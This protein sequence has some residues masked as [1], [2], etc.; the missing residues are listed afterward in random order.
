MSETGRHLAISRRAAGAALGIAAAIVLVAVGSAFGAGGLPVQATAANV[1]QSFGAASG[2]AETTLTASPASGATTAG[3][4]LVV[5]ITVRSSTS[6][7]ATVAGVTDSGSNAWTRATPLAP[8]SKN[9]G[10]IWYA[11]NAKSDSS[12]TVTLS[13]GAVAAF[14]VI[15]VTGAATT[16]PVLDQTAADSGSSAAPSFGIT[17]PTSQADEIVIADIGWNG[18]GATNYPAATTVGYTTTAIEQSPVTTGATGEQ[19]AW[20][21][22]STVGT[23]SYGATLASSVT[24]T[25]AMATFELAA[26]SPTPTPSPT[27]TPTPTPSPTTTPPSGPAHIMLI[28]E[29]NRSYGDIIGN[30]GSAPYLNTLASTYASAT[31]WYAVQHTSEDDYVELISG[32][33][34][35]LPAGKPYAATTLVDELHAQGIPWKAYMENLPSNCYKGTP[36]ANGL[37]DQYHN[38]FRYFAEYGTTAGDW[39]STA[40]LN[41]EGI[42]PYAGSTALVS[43]LNATSAPDFVELIPN[44]CD[45]MHGDRNTGSPCASSSQASL[46]AAG[47]TWLS[48]NLPP[49]LSSSWF[50]QNGIVIITWDEGAAVDDTGC[51]GLYSTGRSHPDD[52]D[53]LNQQGFRTVHRR[54]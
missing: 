31:N 47:D 22:V 13:T 3:D 53:H 19:A 35:G 33:N 41:T 7:A 40:N 23:P 54:R 14:T 45:E 18:K 48:T 44:D 50:A 51:C 27:G 10:E 46:I 15:E 28:V 6:P 25:G 20:E 52:R 2:V 5:S 24:W 8:T 43:A 9:D 30:T 39:C 34:Q 37:Y 36:P 32:A 29:E 49:V 38:A 1:L 26:T 21:N 17:T 16:T 11:A 42:V 4:L 12:V